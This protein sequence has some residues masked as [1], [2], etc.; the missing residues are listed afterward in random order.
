LTEDIFWSHP[1]RLQCEA[2]L[3]GKKD[4]E[5]AVEYEF[6]DYK[7]GLR[8][9]NLASSETDKLI[10]AQEPLTDLPPVRT[11]ISPKLSWRTKKRLNK[12]LIG[13]QRH[14]SFRLQVALDISVLHQ[15]L[16]PIMINYAPFY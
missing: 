11:L 7:G 14:L 15:Y 4:K 12:L 9:R 8:A 3:A 16:S 10:N 5:G 13:F 2:I 1:K 6:K